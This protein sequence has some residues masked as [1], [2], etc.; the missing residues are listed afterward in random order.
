MAIISMLMLERILS[1]AATKYRFVQS[2][3][4][5]N[6]NIGFDFWQLAPGIF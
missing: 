1:I 4:F 6:N 5:W 3:G 2:I